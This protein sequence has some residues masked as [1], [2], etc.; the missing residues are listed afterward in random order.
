MSRGPQ[1][2][3][4]F[5]TGPPLPAVCM[6]GSSTSYAVDP[7]GTCT[8]GLIV[9][10]GMRA[11]RGR[12]GYVFRAGDVCA[13]DPS[14]PHSGQ[15]YAGHDWQARLMILDLAIVERLLSDARGGWLHEPQHREPHLAALFLDAYQALEHGESTMSA[16]SALFELLAVLGRAPEPRAASRERARREPALRRARDLLSDAPAENLSLSE[17]A[18]AAG[19]SRHR[20]S[21]L[22]RA[23]YGMPPHRFQLAARLRTARQLLD[24]REAIASAALH[25]GFAD[26]SHFHRHF[27]RAFGLTPARYAALTVIAPRSDVQDPRAT[28]P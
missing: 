9:S 21:R 27:R 7:I 19:T 17:L 28:N 23:A 12:A 2:V 20:L 4:V 1:T 24:R 13:W 26:Q 5:R 16:E 18:M 25:A 15:P 14:A 11:R 10:G 8:L 6:H 3:T 22:F